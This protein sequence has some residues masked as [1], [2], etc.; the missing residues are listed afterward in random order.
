[1]GKL[2]G[3]IVIVGA[4]LYFY[5]QHKQASLNPE[6]IVNPTYVE[7]HMSLEAR[8]RKFK[9]VLFA[10]AVDEADCRRQLAKIVESVQKAQ[11]S[12]AAGGWSIESQECKAGLA[13][14]HARLFDD[15]PTPVTYLKLAR[16][17][18][19]EREARLI[20]W[21]VSPEESDRVCDG[22][23]AMQKSRKGA[24][25]CIRGTR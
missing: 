13:A 5:F 9:Q 19:A 20:Y 7:I 11:A 25:T 15:E 17:D 6:T 23:A 3:F 24:V 8:D 14:R 22:V 2:F 16:G 12:D 1:M 4:A 21:G 10:Q 18:R